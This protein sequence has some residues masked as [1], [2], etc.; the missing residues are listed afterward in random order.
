MSSGF[1]QTSLA[2]SPTQPIILII[3]TYSKFFRGFVM[4]QV[5]Y[6]GGLGADWCNLLTVELFSG[7]GRCGEGT[8]PHVK[9]ILE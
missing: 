2:Q 5:I 3:A 6:V 9:E 1:D 8:Q 4:E 7:L